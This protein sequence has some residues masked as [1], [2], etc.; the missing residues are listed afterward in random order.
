MALLFTFSCDGSFSGITDGVSDI[1]NS[2]LSINL[3]WQA[4]LT[5]SDGTPL[6]DLGVYIVHYGTTPRQYTNS[7]DVGNTTAV[8]IGDLVPGRIYIAVTAYDKSRNES[9]FSQEVY[10]DI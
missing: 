4:P 7:V 1:F 5:N 8:T 3:S 6:Q 2:G 10:T 9:D